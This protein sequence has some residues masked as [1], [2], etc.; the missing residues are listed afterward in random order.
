MSAHAP[1]SVRRAFALA[2]ER[3]DVPR[4]LMR[5][6]VGLVMDGEA[7][8][9]ALAGLLVALRMKGEVAEELVGAASAMRE[10]MT[11]APVAAPADGSPAP[12]LDTCGTGGDGLSTFNISTAAALV[13]AA[14]GV[15]VAK[16]GNRS[17]SSKSGS[18]DVLEALGVNVSLTPDRVGE[19]I[20]DVGIGF[21]Y[22]PASHG[23]MR[24]AGPV[25]KG[26]GVRTLFNLLGPLTNPAGAGHQLL[27][28][29]TT[30]HAAL[31]ADAL[32]ALGTNRS[33]VVCG[34]DELDEVSLWGE[35]AVFVATP[36]GVT[37]ETW[38]A[39]TLGLAT[40][41]AD[42]LKA[43]G[44]AESAAIIRSVLKGEPGP[45]RAIVT[46]NAAAGLLA[47]GAE[48]EPRAAVAR[49]A[50]SLDAGAAADVL[51]R[52]AAWTND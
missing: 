52:L 10:R 47:V 49:V 3:R 45:A 9:H 5:E 19:C 1:D 6:A 34:N 4:D 16:H 46:A 33:L 11:A 22:A 42:D 12:L 8:S 37:R 35:T 14:C 13:T 39:D 30:A 26:L 24:H 36:D 29:A 17:V 21:A 43:D 51:A 2:L 28:A 15:R 7:D 41:A 50:E 27:G 18:A 44:P 31:I 38:T 25:R 40:I 48:T 32:Q 23:A 20:A